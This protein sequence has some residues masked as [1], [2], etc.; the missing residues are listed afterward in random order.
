MKVVLLRI[1]IDTG[2]GGIHGP[3]S[4]T[5]HLSTFRSRMDTPL[6]NALTATPR[7]GM[8]ES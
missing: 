5:G 8:A 4:L 2:C 7:A 1:G 3:C 6:T